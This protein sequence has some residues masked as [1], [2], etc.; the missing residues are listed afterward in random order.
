MGKLE[1]KESEYY[2]KD[3]VTEF[4]VRIA[5][6]ESLFDLIDFVDPED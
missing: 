1:E 4:L 5:D 6:G 2:T 3:G